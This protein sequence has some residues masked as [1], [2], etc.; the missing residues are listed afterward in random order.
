MDNELVKYNSDR[1]IEGGG[2]GGFRREREGLSSSLFA[3]TILQTLFTAFL[4]F[5]DQLKWTTPNLVFKK[6]VKNEM[7]M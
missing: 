6:N 5:D 3:F 1:N 7:N 4:A 2:G